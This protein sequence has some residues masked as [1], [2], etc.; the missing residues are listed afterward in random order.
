MAPAHMVSVNLAMDMMQQNI[1]V[2]ALLNNAFN[3]FPS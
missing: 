3:I 2:E 1:I